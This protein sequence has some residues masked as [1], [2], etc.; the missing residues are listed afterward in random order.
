MWRRMAN[1]R[2]MPALQGTERRVRTGSF[3]ARYVH[4]GT[5]PSR[6]PCE[7][8]VLVEQQLCLA[9]LS[10]EDDANEK[11]EPCAGRS[12]GCPLLLLRR[13]H[14]WHMWPLI[15]WRHLWLQ[16]CVLRVMGP[17]HVSQ[18]HHHDGS[19]RRSGRAAEAECVNSSVL[20]CADQPCL[21]CH[22]E[23]GRGRRMDKS[24]R[25][26]DFSG[27][28]FRSARSSSLSCVRPCRTPLAAGRQ[29]APLT[30]LVPTDGMAIVV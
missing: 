12:P 29:S 2:P 14:I 16:V 30:R 21:Q 10:R 20:C 15:I 3:R 23:R 25:R 5:L 7:L 1:M 4:V 9:Q 19:P 22:G 28:R 17:F 8:I 13:R 6:L 27:S 26:T 11:V 24:G 18:R